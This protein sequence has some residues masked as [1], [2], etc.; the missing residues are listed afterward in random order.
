M[1][2]YAI[3]FVALLGGIL[4]LRYV[5]LL[6]VYRDRLTR[7]LT[8][9]EGPIDFKRFDKAFKEMNEVKFFIWF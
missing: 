9:G 3:L 1:L 2:N 5:A 8:E 7:I 4:G 6:E